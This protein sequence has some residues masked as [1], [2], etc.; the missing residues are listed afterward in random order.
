MPSDG[1][2]RRRA[3]SVGAG[4]DGA[5]EI[6]AHAMPETTELIWGM[7]HGRPVLR[8]DWPEGWRVR[9]SGMAGGQRLEC[10][11]VPARLDAPLGTAPLEELA[12]GRESCCVLID[13]MTRPTPAARILP[14]LIDRLLAGGLD[15]RDIFF[16]AANGTH[17]ALTRRDLVEKVGP[18]VCD[19]F[20]VMR[21]DTRQNLAP[22]DE[23]PGLGRVRVNRFYRDADLKLAV[24]GVVPHFMCGISGGAKIVLPAVCGLETI[25]ATHEH[26]VEGPPAAVGVVEGN[27]MRRMME[28]TA[29]RTGLDFTA[30]CVFDA[31]GELCGLFCGEAHEAYLAAVKR[32]REVYATEVPY[33]LDVAVF[34]AFPKD[35]E[36]I[37]AMAA[38]NVWADRTNPDRAVVRPGGTIVV[39][40]ACS[41]GL[42]AH[43]LIE[44]GRRHFKRRDRHGSFRNVLRDRNLLFLAPNV[45]AATLHRYYLPR[46]R[47]FR[48]WAGVRAA[49]QEMHPHGAEAAVFPCSA[50][51]VDSEFLGEAL[52]GR[53][54]S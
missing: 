19:R 24:T 42:G 5:E 40:S 11:E 50:L 52:K 2:T 34:N 3:R 1:G 53:V 15:E 29:R 22:V 31:E 21:H 25:A 13:D 54:G 9:V 45:S 8:L 26:T 35:T 28:D 20:V 17:R 6:G 36:F 41:E 44:Y 7:W 48:T 43:E 12:R 23:V 10:A 47:L 18:E 4:D 51:Q 14:H 49:L 33:G 16:I 38:L 27:R 46:A 30:N 39:I 32:A 37:Q